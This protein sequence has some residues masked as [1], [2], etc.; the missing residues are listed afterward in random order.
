ML[1]MTAT[2]TA[3]ASP[4]T[5]AGCRRPAAGTFSITDTQPTKTK[6]MVPTNSAKQGWYNLSYLLGGVDAGGFFVLVSM[7]VES[8]ISIFSS[9]IV[10]A[11]SLV[12]AGDFC[13]SH[14]S[15]EDSKVLQGAGFIYC[16]VS[17]LKTNCI[18]RHKNVKGEL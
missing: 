16:A 17:T 6:N 1:S 8:S 10:A 18:T 12:P 15:A 11:A 2:N 4:C 13:D 9:P 3:T 5:R 14:Q 7:R